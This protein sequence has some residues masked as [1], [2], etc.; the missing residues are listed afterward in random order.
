[1]YGVYRVAVGKSMSDKL[2]FRN[3]MKGGYEVPFPG[4]AREFGCSRTYHGYRTA[5]NSIT[6]TEWLR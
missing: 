4:P 6:F 1:M 2:E 3:Q 5:R